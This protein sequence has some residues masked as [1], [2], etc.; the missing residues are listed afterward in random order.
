MLTAK[1]RRILYLSSLYQGSSHDYTILQTCFAPE[2]PWFKGVTVRLDLGFQGFQSLYKYRKV[3][4]PIKKK[5]VA[6]GQSNE[7]TEEQKQ[8]NKQQAQERIVVEHCIGGMK[9]YRILSHRRRIKSTTLIHT[10]IGVCAGLW[11]FI[12]S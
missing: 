3:F 5:R 7:L 11:N 1:N 12:L 4:L 9:R 2:L 8:W 10:I 6:K